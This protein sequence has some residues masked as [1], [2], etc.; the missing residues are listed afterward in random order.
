MTVSLETC[1]KEGT[2][3]HPNAKLQVRALVL[4]LYF[5]AVNHHLYYLILRRQLSFLTHPQH[6]IPLRK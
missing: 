3:D 1:P 5:L 2:H 6:R 4:V